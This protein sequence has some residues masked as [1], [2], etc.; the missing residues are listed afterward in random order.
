M[1]LEKIKNTFCQFEITSEFVSYK[2]LV[3]GHINNTYLIE[4]T[5]KPFYVLQ[6]L[7]HAVFKDI[8]GLTANKVKVSA[9]LKTTSSYASLDFIAAKNGNYY[10][11]DT[12]GD[13]WN[14]MIFLEDSIT[15][16]VVP[17][18]EIAFEAGKLFGDFLNATANFDATQLIETIPDFHNMEFRFW[19]FDEAL[20]TASEERKELAKNQLKRV[21]SLREEMLI[22]HQ[23][24]K[25]GKIR[26]IVTH[27]DTKVSNAL[28]TQNNKGLCVI[29]LDTVMPGIIHYDFGDAIRTI[30]TTAKEDETDL[31]KVKFNLSYF[32]SFTKGFLSEVSNSISNFEAQYL[33]LS[34][35]AITF[36]MA[37]RMLT[38]FLNNDTYYKTAYPLH[39][40]DR[41]KNQL[42]LIEE[43]ELV[44]EEMKEVVTQCLG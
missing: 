27:N 5:Q 10:Y 3:S 32:E 42:Q 23:L 35:K 4:T 36:I 8:V 6:Q 29:D 14:L 40:L 31:S 18:T 24:K 11:Q 26:L 33:P 39:N 22:L 17:N 28:F 16:D 2:E 41:V 43:M 44:F 34:A 1:S 19:Q 25:S 20:K 15:F 7:N 13:Y 21:E 9:H 12:K 30:C 38:D 37:L